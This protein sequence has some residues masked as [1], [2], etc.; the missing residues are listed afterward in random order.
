MPKIIRDY[1]V[2]NFI[3]VPDILLQLL[4]TP[5]FQR[6]RYIKQPGLAHYVFPTM[7]HTRF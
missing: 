7:T 3:E 4:D 2:Y 1:S 6:L 5:K